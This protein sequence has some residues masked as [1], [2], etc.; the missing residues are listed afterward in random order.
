MTDNAKPDGAAPMLSG[1][2]YLRDE[3][4]REDGLTHNRMT[5]GFSFQG[6]LIASMSLMLATPWQYDGFKDQTLA[7]G[8]VA[9]RLAVLGGI[10]VIGLLVAIGTTLGVFASTS[11]VRSVK[12]KWEEDTTK[13]LVE[14]P[15]GFPQAY[16]QSRLFTLGGWFAPLTAMCFIL[17]WSAYLGFYGYH[18]WGQFA[19]MA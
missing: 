14:I 15:E 13:G 19:A 1:Y 5:V 12:T 11:S 10:G 4:K 2:D 16:G 8:L 9:F 3:I 6:F 17:L 7:N 18:L